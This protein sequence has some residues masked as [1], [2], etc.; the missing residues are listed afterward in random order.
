MGLARPSRAIVRRDHAKH[1]PRLLAAVV[2]S[3]LVIAACGSS[4]KPSTAAG[5]ST[6]AMLDRY[7]AC[8]RNHSVSGFPDPSTTETPNSFGIDGY[9][10]DV[11]TTINAQSPAYQSADKTCQSA[12]GSGISSRG[13]NAASVAKA[14]KRAL[15]HAVCM[16]EH[17]VPNFPDPVI[18]INGHGISQASGGAG[19]NPRS[20]AFQQAQRICGGA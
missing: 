9:N 17:G 7:A 13:L 6:I 19:I 14:R 15:A 5:S 8:M 4:S 10:F 11:P 20:P 18:T 2:A 3:A 12:L 1:Q 16:R